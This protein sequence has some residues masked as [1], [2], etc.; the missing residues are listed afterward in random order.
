MTVS[1]HSGVLHV[2]VVEDNQPVRAHALR[3][4]AS[5]GHIVAA[6]SDGREALALL[7]G[8]TRCD[9]LMTDVVM[10]GMSGGQLA[11]A[12]RLLRPNLPVLFV[13]GHTEDPMVEQ[14]RREGLAVVLLKP[15]RRAALRDAIGK[16]VGTR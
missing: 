16:A 15:Y 4:V 12:A 6:A 3:V 5:L 8:D 7:A 2:L 1:D 9:L 10:P 11:H 14:L 13:T